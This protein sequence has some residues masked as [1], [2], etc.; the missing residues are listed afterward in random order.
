MFAGLCAETVC[1]P[2]VHITSL[3]GAGAV[4][5]FCE[6]GFFG[7]VVT[8]PSGIQRRTCDRASE[9]FGAMD[10]ASI[11]WDTFGEGY[12]RSL[13]SS[14]DVFSGH[15]NPSDDTV[16][17]AVQGKTTSWIAMGMRSVGCAP[18]L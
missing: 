4:Q 7:D 17:F 6:A 16:E 11:A 8:M 1:I 10:I 5:C 9:A 13:T 18:S 12:Q 2:V 3:N 14:A 15:L